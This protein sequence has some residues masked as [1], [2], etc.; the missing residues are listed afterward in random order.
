MK[1]QPL[2][3]GKPLTEEKLQPSSRNIR[4]AEEGRVAGPMTKRKE[5]GVS[6]KKGVEKTK[7]LVPPAR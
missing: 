2:E 5:D 7:F 3:T 6:D 4:N 1:N